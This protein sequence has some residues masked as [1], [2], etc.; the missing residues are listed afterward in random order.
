[1][2][3]QFH[4]YDDIDSLARRAF[5]ATPAGWVQLPYS[6]DYTSDYG[7][8]EAPKE[9]MAVS[10]VR[11]DLGLFT[12]QSFDT[13]LGN[14]IRTATQM[15]ERFAGVHLLGAAV[16]ASYA[17]VS[18]LLQLPGHVSQGVQIQL[19]YRNTNGGMTQVDSVLMDS[20]NRSYY[21]LRLN[22]LGE[23]SAVN[24]DYIA[25]ILCNYTVVQLTDVDT[26]DQYRQAVRFLVGV[27]FENRGTG[28]LAANP[29]RINDI[30]NMYLGGVRRAVVA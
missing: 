6:Y 27:M 3:T 8:K 12:D 22:D 26:I 1:M 21:I 14:Y 24:T 13:L 19:H 10:E 2:R 7:T 18:T 5:R 30:L 29:K 20:S 9:F 25:P 4:E 15:V 11:D 28:D 17:Y 23:F 16:V